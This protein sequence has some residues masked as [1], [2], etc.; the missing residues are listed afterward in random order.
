MAVVRFSDALKADIRSRA[1]KMFDARLVKAQEVDLTKWGNETDFGQF[2]YNNLFSSE[3]RMHMNAI[4]DFLP[5]KSYFLVRK[6]QGH[7]ANLTVKLG[8]SKPWPE[9]TSTGVR[10]V[11]SA[12]NR[13]DVNLEGDVWDD[14]AAE[15]V[16][17]NN[18]VKRVHEER[19]T[20]VKGVDVLINRHTTLAPA[21]RE[22]KPLWDLLAE[23]TKERHKKKVVRKRSEAQVKA[24]LEAEGIDLNKMTSV[25]GMNRLTG[26][27][28]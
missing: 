27:N 28:S 14:L 12:M 26:G 9:L 23:E 24:E 11:G 18:N 1:H 2:V 15:I 8:V 6:V 25:V 19:E 20:F 13:W 17:R 7:D 10:T 22:W 21:L 5:E 3:Q 16:K 4:K